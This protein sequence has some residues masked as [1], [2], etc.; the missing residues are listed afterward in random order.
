MSHALRPLLHRF[1]GLKVLVVGEAM[2]DTYLEGRTGR[3]CR[4]APVPIVDLDA[5]RDAP[6]GA[7]NAAVNAAA[8]GANVHFLSVVGDDPEG[9]ILGRELGAR[10]VDPA[11]VLVDPARRTLAKHRVVAASQ[12]LVRFD[13]GS[14]GPVDPATERRLIRR[15]RCGAIA[16]SE[17]SPPTPN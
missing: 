1:R 10:G 5:R 3:L 6:G 11:G 9:A 4:E 7:A 17:R 8:L 16:D 15:L 14:T 12:L 13:Q 2:L